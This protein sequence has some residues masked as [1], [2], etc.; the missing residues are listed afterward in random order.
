MELSVPQSQPI[1]P[2]IETKFTMTE[3][4]LDSKKDNAVVQWCANNWRTIVAE[5]FAT[6]SLLL[7]GCMGLCK[8]REELSSIYGAIGFGTIVAMNIQIFGHISGAH[9][10][11]AVSLGAVL[12]GTMTVPVMIAYVIAQ[13][14]GAIV[15]FGLVTL[16]TSENLIHDETCSTL[17]RTDLNGLQA[18]LIEIILTAALNFVNCGVWDPRNK[19]LQDSVAIKFG[20][21]ITGLSIAGGTLTGASMNPARTL[22]PALWNSTWQYHWLYWIGP[23][24]GGSLSVLFYKIIWKPSSPE[25]PE[26]QPLDKP[27]N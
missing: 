23:L 22:G 20:L 12:F 18:L 21:V 27:M 1:F 14:G 17:P 26:E 16:L 9:M 13:C 24:F 10:N 25:L 7:F 8:P 15:G 11:P 3:T 5:F 6:T 4:P 2:S 19:H